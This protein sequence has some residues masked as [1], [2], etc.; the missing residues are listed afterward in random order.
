M[1]TT[2]PAS[3][4]A[5]SPLN[6]QPVPPPAWPKGRSGNP[7]GAPQGKA[8]RSWLRSFFETPATR[9]LLL[10]KI[11]RDLEHD[12][13]GAFALKALA[14]V[15]GEPKQT[16]EIEMRSVAERYAAARGMSP[17]LLISRARELAAQADPS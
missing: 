7:G 9:A 11:T 10:D 14:Y 2:N 15:Y 3:E 5:V 6:G 16:V 1:E 13:P 8:F 4:Q 12:G 17:D